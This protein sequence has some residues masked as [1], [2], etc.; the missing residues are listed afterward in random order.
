MV[1]ILRKLLFGQHGEDTGQG[2]NRRTFQINVGVR[3]GGVL[4]PKMFSSVLHWVRPKGRTWAEGRR[5]FVW[6]RSW[7]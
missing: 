3:Q 7:K 5:M 2:G 6:I 4:S 1:W